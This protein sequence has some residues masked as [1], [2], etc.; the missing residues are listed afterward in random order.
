MIP[1]DKMKATLPENRY[2]LEFY[3]LDKGRLVRKPEVQREWYA[4]QGL[5]VAPRERDW[6]IE[7]LTAIHADFDRDGRAPE[8]RSLHPDLP[9]ALVGDMEPHRR[10]A[11]QVRA[12]FDF[13]RFLPNIKTTEGDHARP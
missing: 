11:V 9:L 8:W 6:V 13:E 2:V 4:K 7:R 1:L 12:C 10:V 3:T 5:E